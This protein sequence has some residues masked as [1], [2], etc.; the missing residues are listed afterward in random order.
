MAIFLWKTQV[1]VG[2]SPVKTKNRISRFAPRKPVGVEIEQ[3]VFLVL[4]DQP[5]R[6]DKRD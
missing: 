6:P 3:K 1:K 2:K 4:A 5:V